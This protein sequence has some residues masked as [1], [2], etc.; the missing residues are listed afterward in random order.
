MSKRARSVF[1]PALSVAL[2]FVSV[3][4]LPSVRGRIKTPPSTLRPPDTSANEPRPPRASQNPGSENIAP[5]RVEAEI[6]T[7]TARGFLP[8][9][10]S[11]PKGPFFLEVED[12]SGLPEVHVEF[13]VERGDRVFDVRAPRERADWNQMVDLPPGHYVL[14]EVGHPDWTCSITI[15]PQ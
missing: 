4:A 10:I 13:R 6:V 12:R 1:W 15:K 2:L 9:Q 11:R 7:I 8:A 5:E 3:L 14:S